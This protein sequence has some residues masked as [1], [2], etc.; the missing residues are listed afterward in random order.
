MEGV[1]TILPSDVFEA[2]E[3]AKSKDPTDKFG[4]KAFEVDLGNIRPANNGV[5]YINFRILKK[6]YNAATKAVTWEFIPLNLKFMNLT[7]KARIHPPGSAK[8]KYPGARLQFAG[9]SK[10]TRAKSANSKEMVDELYG[11]A[12]IAIYN[13]FKRHMAR[14]LKAQ[15]I[16]NSKTNI[17]STIQTER[18]TDEKTQKKEKL[19]DEII[20]VDVP[21]D[22]ETVG[23]QKVIKNDAPPKNDIY[24]A[25][26]R[27][28]NPKPKQFPFEKATHEEKPLNYGNIGDFI[29]AGSSCSGVDCMDSVCLSSQGIS[30]PS[31]ATLLVVKPSK[32]FKPVP[33]SVFKANEFDDMTGAA[34]EAPPEEEPAKTEQKETINPDEVGDL[35]GGVDQDTFDADDLAG[36]AEGGED[37]GEVDNLDADE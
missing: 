9:S 24:D 23:Q 10:F 37:G 6:R 30:L 35:T 31:K 15:K 22:G 26:K 16:F 2:I 28:E 3:Y 20:R 34:V 29:T 27:I 17:A 32:G 11:K 13:A 33:T 8:K 25:T 5:R 18:I 14:L 36:A 1:E 21:F 7:T 4:D 12:K 19:A